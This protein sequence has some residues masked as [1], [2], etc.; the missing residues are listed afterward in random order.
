MVKEEKPL[1]IKC[2]EIIEF[3]SENA[4]MSDNYGTNLNALEFIFKLAHVARGSCKHPDWEE[5]AHTCYEKFV[6][7]GI[8]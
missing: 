4:A 3:I 1:R 8:L 6:K 7:A 5:E 2:L